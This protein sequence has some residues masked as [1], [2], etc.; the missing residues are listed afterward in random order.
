LRRLE[1]AA[2]FFARTSPLLGYDGSKEDT[3]LEKPPE[4]GQLAARLALL[5][6]GNGDLLPVL[7]Y[8]AGA[9]LCLLEAQQHGFQDR[10]GPC[11]QNYHDQVV[12]AVEEMRIGK[13]PQVDFWVAGWHFNS[14][15][16]RIVASYD[17]ARGALKRADRI[18]GDTPLR[19]IEHK[20]EK[21][22]SIRTEV[23]SLKHAP[24]GNHPSRGVRFE[25]A[26]EGLEELISLVSKYRT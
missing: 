26:L 5:I 23:D 19:L 3:G 9:L 6:K 24:D 17:R 12:I 15:L 4:I 11:E 1:R 18:Q 21:L 13:M 22:D 8:A 16:V 25:D 10:R 2:L 14:A 20:H 7:D